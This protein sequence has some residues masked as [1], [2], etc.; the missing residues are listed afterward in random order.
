MTSDNEDGLKKLFQTSA[1]Q[2]EKKWAEDQGLK[3]QTSVSESDSE[4]TIVSFSRST[5]GLE[6][7]DKLEYLSS[8]QENKKLLW[9]LW[10][11]GFIVLLAAVLKYLK[12]SNIL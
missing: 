4:N 1:S 12:I 2:E 5:S 6:S 11:L 3:L 10:I 8:I 9:G 7:Q